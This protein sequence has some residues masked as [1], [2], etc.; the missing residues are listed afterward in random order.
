MRRAAIAGALLLA[1]PLLNA[2]R[3]MNRFEV[4]TTEAVSARL[5]LCGRPARALP[6]TVGGF[7]LRIPADCRGSGQVVA[8]YADGGVVNCPVKIVVQDMA[9][10]YRFQLPGR[11]C[12]IG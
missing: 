3:P 10:W 1:A 7:E 4:V 2:C 8:T 11:R 6:K 5:E 12:R 9:A